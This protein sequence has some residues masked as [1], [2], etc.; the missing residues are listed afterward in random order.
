MKSMMPK[1]KLIRDFIRLTKTDVTSG[2]G[3]PNHENPHSYS[4]LEFH[5]LGKRVLKAIAEELGL[6]SGTY[7]IRSNLG[8]T[9]VAGEITLHSEHCYIQFMLGAMGD[10]FMCRS[11]KGR[12][13][14]LGGANIWMKYE[15]LLDLPEACNEFRRI[16]NGSL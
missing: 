9:A 5:R 13:D 6:Q 10:Q 14:L 16:M 15:D 7:D 2:N 8:G 12:K 11:C 4:K 1:T 3:D